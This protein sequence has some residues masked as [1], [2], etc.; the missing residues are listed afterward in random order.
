M[1]PLPLLVP[2][3]FPVLFAVV[4][5]FPIAGIVMDRRVHGRVHPAWWWALLVPVVALLAGE[6]VGATGYATDWV[7]GHVEGTPGGERPA[8]PFLPPGI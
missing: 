5:L 2:Y 1:L 7:A 4:S 3:A 8:G 6:V